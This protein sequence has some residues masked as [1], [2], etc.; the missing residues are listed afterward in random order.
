MLSF[1]ARNTSW[2]SA[3]WRPE[4][5]QSVFPS[6]GKQNINFATAVRRYNN[7]LLSPDFFFE[8]FAPEFG[9]TSY[10]NNIVGTRT[11]FRVNFAI[12]KKSKNTTPAM[13]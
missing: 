3:T 4:E 9:S 11:L 10:A 1:Q 13:H 2:T 7:A 5:G 6:G 12:E 8:N